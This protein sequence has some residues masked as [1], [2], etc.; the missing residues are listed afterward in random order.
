M[1]EKCDI[2]SI[3]R[4]CD[5][6][7]EVWIKNDI[8]RGRKNHEVIVG[9]SSVFERAVGAE[10]NLGCGCHHF[11]RSNCVSVKIKINRNW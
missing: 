11:F 3:V 10:S 1:I 7:I 4:F 8:T 2:L 9:I 6:F 5:I